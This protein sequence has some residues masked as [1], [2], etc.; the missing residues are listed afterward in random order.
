MSE[1]VSGIYE[2]AHPEYTYYS[3]SG[4]VLP[5][6]SPF[7]MYKNPSNNMRLMHN[8]NGE[9]WGIS[10]DNALCGSAM[11]YE[12]LAFAYTA[13]LPFVNV[14]AA[15]WCR[16]ELTE[17][18]GLVEKPVSITCVAYSDD[19]LDACIPGTYNASGAGPGGSCF[20]CPQGVESSLPS[21][22]S[23]SD[24]F[25]VKTDMVAVVREYD[26]VVAFNSDYGEFHTI[27]EEGSVKSPSSIKFISDTQFLVTNYDLNNVVA[28]D[29]DGRV[30][31]TVLEI[32]RPEAVLYFPR[33]N[34]IA[35]ASAGSYYSYEEDSA[36]A[37][38]YFFDFFV[39][40]TNYEPLQTTNATHQ[41]LNGD[42]P[43]DMFDIVAMIEGE[44][45]DEFI[46]GAS[47]GEFD[48]NPYIPAKN[49][50][51]RICVPGTNCRSTR[52]AILAQRGHAFTDISVSPS[53]ETYFIVLSGM[54]YLYEC[55]LNA[56]GAELDYEVIIGTDE[57]GNAIKIPNP[58]CKKFAE[59][60][61]TGDD[62]IE[63]ESAW[64]RIFARL[65]SHSFLS[66]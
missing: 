60:S 43:L 21:S 4:C 29:L 40:Q 38:I 41:I 18:V 1:A 66:D 2:Y 23:V 57:S 16:D 35:V 5:G 27:S 25:T 22:T 64:V 6:N 20:P 65:F 39:N 46:I 19:L 48:S 49:V 59:N 30:L 52:N 9:F 10:G 34:K 42:I 62:G 7:P 50:I 53:K 14:P 28:M 63:G 56:V 54:P 32:V 36:P 47:R 51:Y 3:D 33:L 44:N 45:D 12:Y 37:A 55:D 13:N 8:Y 11:P 58:Y 31:G 26:R 15:W 61:Y 17:G 24:C